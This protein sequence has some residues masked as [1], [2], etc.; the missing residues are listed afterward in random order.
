VGELSQ[1]FI[2][3]A[4]GLWY[5][6][7]ECVTVM[8]LC[9]WCTRT[10]ARPS[11]CFLHY[12][13]S[14]LVCFLSCLITIK[15]WWR[16]RYFFEHRRPS[17]STKLYCLVTEAYRYEQLAQ[18][19]YAAFSR[20]KLN[21]GPIDRK[22]N[23]LPLRITIKWWWWC[24]VQQQQQGGHVEHLMQRLQDATVTLDSNWD[25]NKHVVSCC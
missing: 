21:S 8:S 9:V 13:F 1:R 19:C 17:T 24:L 25:N 10:P 12:I 16:S 2:D 7:L 22:S 5:R 18:G 11:H 14:C 3:G 6:R 4:I 23:A 15:W 20:W